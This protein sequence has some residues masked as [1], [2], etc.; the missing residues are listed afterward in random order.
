MGG[1]RGSSLQ[2]HYSNIN[3]YWNIRHDMLCRFVV[4]MCR[5]V[6]LYVYGKHSHVSK[7]H[8]K[9][10]YINNSV[11]AAYDSQ[12]VLEYLNKKGTKPLHRETGQGLSFVCSN[13]HHAIMVYR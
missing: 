6:A 2:A 12:P 4:C 13:R 11:C 10:H 5:N 7:T 8:E 9:V 1:S 3:D